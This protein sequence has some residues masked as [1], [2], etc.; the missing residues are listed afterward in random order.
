MNDAVIQHEGDTWRVIGFGATRMTETNG[1]TFCHLMSTTRFRKQRNGD[2]PVQMAD[3]IDW[4]VIQSGLMQR[5][6]A[7]RASHSDIV[8]DGGMDPRDRAITAFYTDR[9]NGFHAAK[10][11]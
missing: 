7:Q 4:R 6:E 8:S 11:P 1:Q 2:V 3:W 10:A 5:E 9:A